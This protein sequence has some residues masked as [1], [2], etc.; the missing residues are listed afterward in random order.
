[1]SNPGQSHWLAVKRIMRYIKGTINQSLTFTAKDGIVND[2]LNVNVY[3]DADWAG[4]LDDR[5][6][7]TG[8]VVCI[9][10]STVIWSTK[11][12]KTVSLSS[13]EAEY[14]ALAAAT[15]EAKWVNQ[16]LCELFSVSGMS[17]SVDMSVHV[18]N[19]AAIL[20][21]K[22]DV[23]HDRTKHIDLRYHYVREA[24]QSGLYKLEWV[25]TDKQLADGFTKSLSSTIFNKHF[26]S[27]MNL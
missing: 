1:M 17:L 19:Q 22:N 5:R 9:G 4:D 24:V 26:S 2:K 21:S 11:K 15:Q 7:T 14:M 16:F 10:N 12:Q 8:Y 23:Y 6:S 13:A 3:S 27:I 25:S 20:M 18:D